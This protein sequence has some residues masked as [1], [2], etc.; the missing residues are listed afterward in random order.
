M[1]PTT[2]WQLSRFAQDLN[3]Q[4]RAPGTVSN[5][6]SVIRTLQALK[7]FK[8]VDLYDIALKLHLKGLANL[9][10]YVVKQAEPMTPDL[11]LKISKLVNKSNKKEVACF[12]AVLVGFFLLLRKSNMVP[13]AREGRN[14]FDQ[15]KQFVRKDLQVGNNTVLVNL[16][17]TKTLQDRQKSIKLPLLP[18][19]NKNISP[20]WW[21]NYMLQMI[22]GKPTDPLFMVPDRYNKKNQPL[23]YRVLT[24]QLKLW[25]SQ[26]LGHAKG[27]SLHCLRRG[28]ATWCFNID[29]T[30][31][32]IRLMGTWASDSYKR[33]LDL[34][35]NKRTETMKKITQSID[36][37]FKGVP[38]ECI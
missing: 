35:L 29:I 23:T 18:L 36:E 3:N 20:I 8:N 5:Y 24:A 12:T 9:S 16:R 2:S 17:W 10:D 28:G 33:Y 19:M 15:N 34:D 11:L 13:D 22:P 30:T 27:Y 31:E 37:M 1:F 4:G 21:I 14:G 32:A 26:V 25:V 6:I 38:D 7:G